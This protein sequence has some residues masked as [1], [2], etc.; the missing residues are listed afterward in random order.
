MQFYFNSKPVPR[1]LARI[2]FI[3][4]NPYLDNAEAEAI[5]RGAQSFTGSKFRA[6]LRDYG[7]EVIL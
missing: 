2:I 6:H 3:D 4:C 7:I 1:G 5:F